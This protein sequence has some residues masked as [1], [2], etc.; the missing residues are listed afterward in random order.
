MDRETENDKSSRE[1][2]KEACSEI[3]GSK[4]DNKG[5]V[6]VYGRGGGG[7]GGGRKEGERVGPE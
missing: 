3:K 4:H 7:G 6:F 1:I 2:S 5:R